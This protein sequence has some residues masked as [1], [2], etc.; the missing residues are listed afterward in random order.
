MGPTPTHTVWT[1][2]A[3][4]P[5]PASLSSVSLNLSRSYLYLSPDFN[6]SAPSLIS[7]VYL[8]LPLLHHHRLTTGFNPKPT[9]QSPIIPLPLD[10]S[11]SRPL[12]TLNIT[13]QQ[14]NRNTHH[15]H[16]TPF[17]PR[18][19]SPTIPE[20]HRSSTAPLSQPPHLSRHLPSLPVHLPFAPLNTHHH[21]Q[22]V[23][24]AFTNNNNRS[25]L[26]PPSQTHLLRLNHQS[27]LTT[28]TQYIIQ[29]HHPSISD[30]LQFQPTN[31]TNTCNNRTPQSVTSLYTTHEID[32]TIDR[33]IKLHVVLYL[34]SYICS[35]FFCLKRKEQMFVYVAVLQK[36][37][38][39]VFVLGFVY[40]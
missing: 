5:S 29:P 39:S 31:H 27:I 40:I 37:P 12:S 2:P 35:A 36:M 3:S 1:P 34:F 10:L 16:T 6:L 23:V 17:L 21:H 38:Y 18:L 26:T 14:T 4:P 9:S 24:A 33:E 22:S 19:F 28:H 32:K 7:P 13:K 11:I 25:L 30:N 8:S 15:N 20:R